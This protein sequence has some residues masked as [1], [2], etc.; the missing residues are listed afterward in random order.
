M[1]RPTIALIALVA[2]A[3]A[4][5]LA[6]V[7]STGPAERSA[8][9]RAFQ[10]RVEDFKPPCGMLRKEGLH[11]PVAAAGGHLFVQVEADYYYVF[12]VHAATGRPPLTAWWGAA[13]GN[14]LAEGCR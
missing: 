5:Y 12:G 11:G 10:A 6:A 8:A 7:L 4:G 2:G 9:E 14:A 3:A 1:N 13:R